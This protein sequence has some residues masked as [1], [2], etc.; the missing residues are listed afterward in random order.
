M[1]GCICCDSLSGKIEIPGGIIY[2]TQYW[3]ID[4]CIGPFGV[5]SLIV[6]PK[7]HCVHYWELTGKEAN[8]VGRLLKLASKTI[9]T[10]L[11]P[12]Q[13]YICL[14]SH[15]NWIPCHIHFLL[16]PVWNEMKQEYEKSGGY[17]QVGMVEKQNFAPREKVEEFVKKAKEV[18]EQHIDEK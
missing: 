3:V 5:G 13:V 1:D 8:E 2:S 12:D 16:Q 4:H 11:M 14:W 9:E 18:I 15:M 6:K 10:I 7:R 17:L